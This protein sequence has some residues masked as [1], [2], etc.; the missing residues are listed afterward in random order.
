[1]CILVW[2]KTYTELVIKVVLFVNLLISIENEV[3]ELLVIGLYY[4]VV[5]TLR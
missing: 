2:L 5:V 3:L 1:M 4:E